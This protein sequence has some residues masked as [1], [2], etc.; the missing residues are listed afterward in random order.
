[1]KWVTTSWTYSTYLDCTGSVEKQK[2]INILITFVFIN[3]DNFFKKSW[4]RNTQKIYVKLSYKYRNL[5]FAADETLSCI[6]CP[7]ML[8]ILNVKS[9]IGAH[10]YSVLVTILSYNF[11]VHV[12]EAAKKVIFFSGPAIT[13]II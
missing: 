12:R 8:H 4:S 7:V 11:N 2:K 3:Y 1:M 5:V 10:V 6:K 13:Y 9:E